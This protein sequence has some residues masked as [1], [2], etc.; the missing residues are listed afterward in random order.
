MNVAEHDDAAEII[1]P[2]SVDM[3]AI[4]VEKSSPE[5]SFRPPKRPLVDEHDNYILSDEE[6]RSQRSDSKSTVRA[7]SEEIAASMDV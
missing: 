7:V 3:P 6:V 1:S 2:S 5:E 4:T